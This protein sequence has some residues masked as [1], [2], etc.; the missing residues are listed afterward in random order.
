MRADGSAQRQTAAVTIISTSNSGRASWAWQVARVGTARL[1]RSAGGQ[2]ASRAAPA[3]VLRRFSTGQ[4][5]LLRGGCDEPV[6]TT[7]AIPRMAS[8]VM[9]IVDLKSRQF[10]L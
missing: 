5:Q 1:P 3:S 2:T 9:L 8:S 4:V 10:G 7:V 6:P